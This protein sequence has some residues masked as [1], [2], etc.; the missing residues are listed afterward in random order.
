MRRIA[1][2]SKPPAATRFAAGKLCRQALWRVV[3]AIA[4]YR[5]LF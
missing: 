3:S 4:V 5:I 2:A 1:V